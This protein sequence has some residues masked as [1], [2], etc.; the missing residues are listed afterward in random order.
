MGKCPLHHSPSSHYQ[1]NCSLSL[2]ATATPTRD[3][4]CVQRVRQGSVG[5]SVHGHPTL[6]IQRCGFPGLLGHGPQSH[7]PHWP[8]ASSA[9]THTLGQSQHWAEPSDSANTEQPSTFPLPP[10]ESVL[11][12]QPP[13]TPGLLFQVL[14]FHNGESFRVWYFVF[15]F[16][17]S[18]SLTGQSIVQAPHK[19]PSVQA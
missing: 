5:W 16:F 18:H 11:V 6:P 7:G 15:P 10:A 19:R 3:R 8:L 4:T 12:R 17:L 14:V 9:P 13:G 1:G 2:R